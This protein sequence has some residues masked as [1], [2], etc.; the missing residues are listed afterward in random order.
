MFSDN[1][2]QAIIQ[3]A[4]DIAAD[5]PHDIDAEGVAECAMDAGRLTTIANNKEADAEV[6]ALVSKHGYEAVLKA[7]AEF[8]PVW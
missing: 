4:Q 6:S 3:V 2:K 7:A 1:A 5:L 8:V